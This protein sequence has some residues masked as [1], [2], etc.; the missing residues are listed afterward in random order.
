MLSFWIY[1][2]ACI[3]CRKTVSS[4]C[5]QTYTHVKVFGNLCPPSWNPSWISDVHKLNSFE[6]MY[7]IIFTSKWW[8]FRIIPR[9]GIIWCE[10]Y[11]C[12]QLWLLRN[13]N[14]QSSAKIY[15]TWRNKKQA[16]NGENTFYLQTKHITH[17]PTIN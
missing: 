2:N 7:L 5:W 12:I 3:H 16:W 4:N 9:D 1:E 8:F 6:R 15:K 14:I 10:G 13:V 17:T 11:C